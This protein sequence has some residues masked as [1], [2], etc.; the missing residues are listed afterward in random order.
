V[1]PT[2]AHDSRIAGYTKTTVGNVPRL[3]MRLSIATVLCLFSTHVFG[4]QMLLRCHGIDASKEPFTFTVTI[5]RDRSLVMEIRADNGVASRNGSIVETIVVSETKIAAKQR[6][7]PPAE[8]ILNINLAT[9]QF[10]LK[11]SEGQLKY[12]KGNCDP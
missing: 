1:T 8:R 6:L 3:K 2:T 9:G 7:W 10:D 4:E 12:I 11:I 5:D